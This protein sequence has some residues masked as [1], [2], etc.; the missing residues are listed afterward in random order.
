MGIF[1]S[2]AT[3]LGGAGFDMAN[4][5]FNNA[6]SYSYSKRLANEQLKNNIEYAQWS[7]L[8]L[9]SLNRQGME[10]ARFNPIL[11]ISKGT[12]EQGHT[13][14]PSFQST[15]DLGK[16]ATQSLEAVNASKIAKKTLD[17]M[18]ND[19]ANNTLVSTA[20]ADAAR[21]NAQA[22]LLDVWSQIGHRKWQ[23]EHPD[24]NKNATYLFNQAMQYMGVPA[25]GK[26][27]WDF[28]RRGTDKI[29]EWLGEKFGDGT[30]S[31]DLQVRKYL[32]D[33]YDA[34]SVQPT[35]TGYKIITR[36]G[37]TL[38]FDRNGQPKEK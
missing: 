28:G 34:H 8:N 35:D 5:M 2:V 31:N 29:A 32:G 12:G 27:L 30:S 36:D 19:M 22:H 1:S 9:P 26:A 11:A 38:F 37:R 15:L 10:N 17:K 6:Q 24:W 21:T 25:T 13:A 16:G 14:I 33:K 23:Q 4:T 7:A 3:A 18:D 20:N